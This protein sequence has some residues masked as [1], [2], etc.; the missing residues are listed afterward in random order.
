MR[1]SDAASPTFLSHLP[2]LRDPHLRAA[3]ST[4]AMHTF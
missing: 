2:Q 1:A 4:S 3:L